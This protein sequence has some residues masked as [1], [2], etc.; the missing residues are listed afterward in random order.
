MLNIFAIDPEICR[1]QEWFRYC[2]EHCHPSQGRVIVDLPH[3]QWYENAKSIIDQLVQELNLPPVK[4]QSL[5]NYLKMVQ[6]QLVDRPGT[7][8]TDW[9]YGDFSQFS[10]ITEIE[11]EHQ[12]EPFSFSAIVSPEY[13]EADDERREVPS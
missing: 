9:Y 1:N 4:A 8:W 5:K 7:V 3:G 6:D 2:T 10:W 12:R 11:K 13:E